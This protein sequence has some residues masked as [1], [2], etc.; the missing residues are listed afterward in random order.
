MGHRAG[1]VAGIRALQLPPLFCAALA[2]GLLVPGRSWLVR[3]TVTPIAAVGLGCR[4]VEAQAL[5]VEQSVFWRVLMMLFSPSNCRL[6]R[7]PSIRLSGVSPAL[8]F[9]S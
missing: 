3:Q 9:S 4:S 2:G 7:C 5:S 1:P 6:P 8:N